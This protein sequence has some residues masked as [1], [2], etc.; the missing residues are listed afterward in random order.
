[1]RPR[2]YAIPPERPFLQTLAE[3]LAARAG[4]DPL[5]LSRVTVLLP[6]RRAVRALRDAFLR[7]TAAGK[8]PGTPTL[9]PRMR[10]IGDLEAD[11][12]SFLDGTATGDE[13]TVPP[14]IPELRRQLLLTQ[15]VLKWAEQGGR[16]RLLA[17]QAA[18]LAASLARLLDTVAAEGA[19]FTRL[20]DLVPADLAA[21]WEVVRKLLEIL[22]GA[23][24]SILA[25]EGAIDPGERRNRLLARQAI[26]WCRKAPGD[27]VIAAGLTGGI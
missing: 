3:G 5:A 21:H 23:W 26:I 1:M 6:T 22:P 7:T 15:L 19:S 11:E 16:D 20:R 13:L 9:L 8:E 2:L 14:A 4:A 10:P 12:F 18:K 17:G 24:P 27:P 25:S